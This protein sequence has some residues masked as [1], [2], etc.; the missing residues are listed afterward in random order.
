M[1][2][3]AKKERNLQLNVDASTF[4]ILLTGEIMEKAKKVQPDPVKEKVTDELENVEWG[5]THEEKMVDHSPKRNSLRHECKGRHCDTA[6][7]KL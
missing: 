4:K 5:E 1:K 7:E 6:F 2:K 3:K